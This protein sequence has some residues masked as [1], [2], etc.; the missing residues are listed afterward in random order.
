MIALGVIHA[1]VLFGLLRQKHPT[2]C[3]VNEQRPGI[4]ISHLVR[5]TQV[6]LGF[7]PVFFCIHCPF[8]TIPELRMS[9]TRGLANLA[10][11]CVF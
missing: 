8:P 11:S 10:I 6:P 9:H 3:Y 5:G 1:L 7:A 4:G 2:R